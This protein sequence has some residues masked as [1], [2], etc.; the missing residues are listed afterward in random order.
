MA[1]SQYDE[2]REKVAAIQSRLNQTCQ[3]IRGDRHLSDSGR[4][5]LMSE[6]TLAAH[7]EVAALKDAF[8]NHREE[9]RKSLR[10]SV[11]G[12]SNPTADQVMLMRDARERAKNLQSAEDAHLSLKLA[13]QDGDTLMARAIASVAATKHWGEVVDHYVEIAPPGTAALLER[14]NDIPEGRNTNLVDSKVFS[15]RPPSELGDRV[16]VGALQQWA[17]AS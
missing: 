16:D 11:F 12:M 3:E 7:R 13:E 5:G 9:R 4:R 14:L 10:Q 8:V 1:L 6:A 15:I 2:S 17:E